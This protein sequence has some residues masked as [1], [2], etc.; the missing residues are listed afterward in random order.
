MKLIGRLKEYVTKFGGIEVK[1][2]MPSFNLATL[3]EMEKD[4]QYTIEITELKKKRSLDQNNMLWGLITEICRK[5]DGNASDKEGKYLN[6]LRMAGIKTDIVSIEKIALEDFMRRCGA[7]NYFL[8]DEFK[9][10]T[11]K[12]IAVIEVI[13]G[14]SKFNTSEMSQLIDAALIYAENIGLNRGYWESLFKENNL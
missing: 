2:E 5:E 14:S 7:R 3:E 12:E 10:E 1:I 9:S 6:L 11:G 4:K 13:Y 8:L